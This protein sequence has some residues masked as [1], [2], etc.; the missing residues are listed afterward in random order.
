[1]NTNYVNCLTGGDWSIARQGAITLEG[2]EYSQIMECGFIRL[3]GNC[4]FLSGYNRDAYIYGNDFSWIGESS[5]ASWGYTSGLESELPGGG[6][7][8]RN[9]DQPRFTVIE[10]N[11]AHELGIWEKQASFYFQA[12]SAQARLINNVFFNGPRAGVKYFYFYIYILKYFDC[13]LFSAK[14]NKNRSILMMVLVVI[15]I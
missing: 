15:I 4:I 9:G 2:T 7:D 5:I 3:D 14:Q 8:G 10:D 13:F 12:T 6:P 1:M 11:M